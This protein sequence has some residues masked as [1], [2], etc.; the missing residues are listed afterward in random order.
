MN[1]LFP[2]VPDWDVLVRDDESIQELRFNGNHEAFVNG[3]F[4]DFVALLPKK[5]IWMSDNVAV[6]EESVPMLIY[7]M[8][9]IDTRSPDR[10][11][12][13]MYKCEFDSNVAMFMC[14]KEPDAADRAIFDMLL[15]NQTRLH[16]ID[17]SIMS[18]NK[19]PTSIFSA[20]AFVRFLAANTQLQVLKLGC[21]R[22]VDDTRDLVGE[23]PRGVHTLELV[24][25]TFEVQRFLDLFAASR[26]GIKTIK[27]ASCKEKNQ[28]R[29]DVCFSTVFNALMKNPFLTTLHLGDMHQGSTR[30]DLAVIKE[31]FVSNESLIELVI[32]GGL[33]IT[34]KPELQLFVEG[35]ASARKLRIIKLRLQKVTFVTPAEKSTMF[36]NA[37]R[38]CANCSLEE[39][40]FGL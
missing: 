24:A 12:R 18:P 29:N 33:V 6:Y 4:Q 10:H 40:E 3:N 5:L 19:E 32:V 23:L 2:P 14:L 20:G 38:D 17:F 21:V 37:L 31:A 39:V 26:R 30:S 28:V 1:E 8:K 35:I 11:N 25:C 34:D 16:V 15:E 36:A 7:L 22:L 9:S 13:W 27:M